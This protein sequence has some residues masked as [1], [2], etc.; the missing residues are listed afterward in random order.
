MLNH[1]RFRDGGDFVC[2]YK[3]HTQKE[4]QICATETLTWVQ[5]YIDKD[6]SL[7]LSN[8]K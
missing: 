2:L 7:K 6:C 8:K 3:L 1:S 4:V 5:G